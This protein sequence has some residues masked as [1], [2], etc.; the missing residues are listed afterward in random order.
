MEG[1]RIST[2]GLEQTYIAMRLRDKCF[3]KSSDKDKHYFFRLSY[4]G[5]LE[6]NVDS[7]FVLTTCS[8][9][10]PFTIARE[11]NN[12]EENEHIIEVI[13]WKEITKNDYE[14][15]CIEYSSTREI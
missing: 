6:N 15:F 5:F 3:K 10:H 7:E 1:D 12:E 13:S 2:K 14:L 11:I 4:R 8:N 9:K